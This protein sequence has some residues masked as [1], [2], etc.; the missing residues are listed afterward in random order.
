[1]VLPGADRLVS[2]SLH[3]VRQV[4]VPWTGVPVPIPITASTREAITVGSVAAQGWR[5]AAGTHDVRIVANTCTFGSW[6]LMLVHVRLLRQLV[7]GNIEPRDAPSTCVGTARFSVAVTD[8]E[9]RPT[10][11]FLQHR[12]HQED[13]LLNGAHLEEG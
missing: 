2:T 12:N 9:P 6:R 4:G 8:S 7:R 1:V 3:P 5:V 11:T 10:R 13:A